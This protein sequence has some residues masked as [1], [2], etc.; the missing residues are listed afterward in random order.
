MERSV[1]KRQAKE[2]IKGNLWTLVAIFL[3]AYFVQLILGYATF[4]A[5][6]V[7][8]LL[9]AGSV[10][11]SMAAT[12][13]RLLKKQRKPQIE[14]LLLGFRGGNFGRG[15][16]GHLRYTIFVFLWTLLFI[17]PG[18]IKG[19][20]YSQMF[21]LMA[22]D[23]KLEP[24][25][26]QARSVDMMNGHKMELLVLYLSFIPWVLLTAATL[27]IALIYVVPYFN[28]TLAAYHSYL[29]KETK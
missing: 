25:E 18:I 13:L 3:V 17:V 20:S 24:S 19:F 1:L 11:L 5:G 15:L 27:G 21:Y 2:A 28:A 4:W 16:I 9:V 6:G 22:D 14:D 26:A 7:A 29:K 10:T 8:G 12:F 23:P